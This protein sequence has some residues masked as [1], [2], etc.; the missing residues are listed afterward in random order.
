MLCIHSLDVYQSLEEWGAK[1]KPHPIPAFA[2]VHVHNYIPSPCFYNVEKQKLIYLI[3][4][5]NLSCVTT[6]TLCV[7]LIFSNVGSGGPS[8]M[9][10][11]RL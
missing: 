6:V 3:C 10:L 2:N 1:S 9:T 8:N 4:E 5:I 7:G 11:G